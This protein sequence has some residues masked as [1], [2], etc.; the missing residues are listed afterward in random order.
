MFANVWYRAKRCYVDS[1][2]AY[3]LKIKIFH[4]PF[5]LGALHDCH[6]IQQCKFCV[7]G[8]VACS[9]RRNVSHSVLHTDKDIDAQFFPHQ[10]TNKNKF[11]DTQKQ[12]ATTFWA[13]FLEC[14]EKYCNSLCVDT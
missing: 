6:E 10:E 9:N 14:R 8:C 11:T 1:P 5:L 4:L 12:A 3:T 2:E 13:Q 7:T